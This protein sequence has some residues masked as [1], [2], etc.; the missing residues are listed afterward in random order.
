MRQYSR[1]ISLIV[2]P[3]AIGFASVTAVA[4]RIFGPAYVS[5]FAPSSIVSIVS[6]LTAVGAVYAAVLLAVGK[7]RWYMAANIV[8]VGALGIVAYIATPSLGLSGTALG[9]ASLMIVVALLYAYA[10]KREGFFKLDVR[11]LISASLASMPMG[12]VVFTFLSSL[13]SF[14]VQ[15]LMLPIVIVIGALLYIASLRV[16]R[17]LTVQDFAVIQLMAP[18]NSRRL[19]ELIALVAGVS[20]ESTLA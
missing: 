20:S 16:L 9:R 5:G 3:I 15:L 10:A 19:I 17:V 4:L 2:I 13:H 18:L 11:A 8:G 12:V 1:Y 6:G 14:M 7:L